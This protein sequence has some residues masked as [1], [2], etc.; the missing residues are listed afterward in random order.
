[1]GIYTSEDLKDIENIVGNMNPTCRKVILYT[2]TMF[3]FIFLLYIT[4]A[5]FTY[6]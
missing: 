6:S 1:M 3:I 2:Q 4:M 5:I